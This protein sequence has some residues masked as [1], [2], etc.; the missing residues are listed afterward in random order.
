[1]GDSC[2]ITQGQR[3]GGGIYVMECSP[4]FPPRSVLLPLAHDEHPPTP[5]FPFLMGGKRRRASC[6]TKKERKYERRA[7][8]D[9]SSSHSWRLGGSSISS[10]SSPHLPTRGMGSPRGG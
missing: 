6:H 9:L 10:S 5:C 1:M 4:L 2:G 3:G 7:F 8:D